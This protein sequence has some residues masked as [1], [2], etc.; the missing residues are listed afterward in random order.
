MLTNSSSFTR[1]SS[2]GLRGVRFGRIASRPCNESRAG[3]IAAWR[4][5]LSWRPHFFLVNY[6]MLGAMAATTALSVAYI[7]HYDFGPSRQQIRTPA[8]IGAIVIA[9]LVAVEIFG[10]KLRKRS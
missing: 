7:A 5:H 3:A 8:V 10:K 1:K 6:L 2:G 9:V 4:R